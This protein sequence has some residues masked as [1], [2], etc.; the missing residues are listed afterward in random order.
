MYR[1]ARAQLSTSLERYRLTNRAWDNWKKIGAHSLGNQV[2][3]LERLWRAGEI[4]TT[5]YLVQINQ[6]LDT[7][8][9]A[10]ELRGRLWQS[11]FDWLA[12]SGQVEGWLNLSKSS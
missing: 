1:R 4:S 10:E 9:A 6:T 12:A 7:Q 8:T 3:L 5:E 2:T 11:W